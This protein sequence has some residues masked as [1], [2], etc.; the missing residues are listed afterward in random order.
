MIVEIPRWTNPKMEM[1]MKETLNPIM[2]EIQGGKLRYAPNVFP[3]H[4]CIWNYGAFPQVGKVGEVRK[5]KVLGAIALIDQG[6]TDWKVF[7]IDITDPLA[8]HMKDIGDIEK[9]YNGLFEASVNWFR[10]YK[11]NLGKQEN[12]FAFG[13]KPK[14]KDFTVKLVKSA[15]LQW[16]DIVLGKAQT[17]H[18]D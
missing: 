10:V 8:E 9:Q 15:H 5:V 3:H 1:K 18:V 6:E 2:Q 16:K 13:G 7:A 17:T 14:D 11:M 12:K 4:G